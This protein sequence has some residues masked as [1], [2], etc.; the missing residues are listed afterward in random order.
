MIRED[1]TGLKGEG[2][3]ILV[4]RRDSKVQLGHLV[5]VHQ[6]E[7]RDDTANIVCCNGMRGYLPRELPGPRSGII[8]NRVFVY[9]TS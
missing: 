6:C 9:L 4:M 2:K 5:F 3:V 1:M 7:S 8:Y